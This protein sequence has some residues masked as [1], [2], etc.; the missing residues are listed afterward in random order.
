KGQP[1]TTRATLTE[2]VLAVGPAA[3]Q[4]AIKQ[5]GTN[6]GGFFNVN[7]AHPLENASKISDFLELYAITLIPFALAFTFGRMVKDRRQGYA[8]VAVMAILALGAAIALPIVESGG[9]PRLDTNG[10]TQAV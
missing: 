9:N 4:I 7:S 5:I 10:V 2:Q 3:S 1:K 8:V 6:G